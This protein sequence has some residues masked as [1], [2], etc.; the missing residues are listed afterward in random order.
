MK[1]IVAIAAVGV[2]SA[3]LLSSCGSKAPEV[4]VIGNSSSNET[5]A[6][7]APTK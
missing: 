5:M 6:S 2:L 7:P 4:K 1:K 3:L